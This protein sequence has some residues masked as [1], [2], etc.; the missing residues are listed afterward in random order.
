MSDLLITNLSKYV[1]LTQHEKEI[2]LSLFTAKKYRKHQ[3]IVQE[4]DVARHET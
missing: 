4:G 1:E 3:Y 2:I